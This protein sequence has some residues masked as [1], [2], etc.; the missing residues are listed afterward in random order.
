MGLLFVLNTFLCLQ[1]HLPH[2]PLATNA[3]Q[4]AQNG[5]TFFKNLQS[6]DG[7]WPSQYGGPMILIPGFVIGSYITKMNFKE[8]E[9]LE[10]IR[11]IMNRA[12]L[13][14]GGWGL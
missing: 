13:A 12:H 11:Y 2:L 5:Y 6:H 14:D 7:H 4:A 8:V 3:Q 10:M 9:R 1:K